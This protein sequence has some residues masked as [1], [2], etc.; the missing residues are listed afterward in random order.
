M[1]GPSHLRTIWWHLEHLSPR[2]SQLL[3]PTALGRRTYGKP[4]GAH[5]LMFKSIG[6]Y[7]MATKASGTLGTIIEKQHAACDLMATASPA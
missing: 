3:S 6:G 1:M 2:A 4:A 5:E 7:L